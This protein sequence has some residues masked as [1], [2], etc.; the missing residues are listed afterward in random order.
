MP[1]VIVSTQMMPTLPT[2]VSAEQDVFNRKILDLVEQIYREAAIDFNHGWDDLRVPLTRDKQ[3]QSSKPDYDFTNMGLLFPQNDATEIVYLINQMPHSM[4]LKSNIS[5][6]IHWV[7]SQATTPTWK[8]DYR[9][10]KNG[11]DP[12]G[13][14]TT[15][16]ADTHVF[17]Y[18]SGDILQISSFPDIVGSAIDTIS[19]ILEIRLYRDDNDVSGDVL[20]KEF[21][22]HYR[23][24][25]IGSQEE[26]HKMR[27]QS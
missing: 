26:Y 11:A 25:A 23:L 5:P 7:Q 4:K 15:I 3:G 16:T 20:A 19:S 9:W 13:S 21:D 24:D 18:T 14:F 27:K 22:I 17:T 8:L 12:T 10:Y 1:S 6:H 2:G